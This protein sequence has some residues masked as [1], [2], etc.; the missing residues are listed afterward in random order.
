MVTT[1]FLFYFAVQV[2]EKVKLS[3]LF[4]VEN[5]FS[6]NY[7]TTF[8]LFLQTFS[9]F[10]AILT[11]TKTAV[12]TEGIHESNSGWCILKG[13]GIH[14]GAAISEISVFLQLFRENACLKFESEKNVQGHTAG[15]KSEQ[16]R[17]NSV[18]HSGFVGFF[19][20]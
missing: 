20:F 12:G 16:K 9:L 11:S 6:N 2:I 14:A 10:S 5:C 18:R 13:T 3:R 15:K 17:K 1:C 4:I 7:Y 8:L 19:Q